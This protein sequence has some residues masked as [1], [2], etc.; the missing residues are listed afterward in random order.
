[1]ATQ[2]HLPEKWIERL[3]SILEIH[4]NHEVIRFF[5]AWAKAEGGDAEWNPLNTTNHVKSLA[6]GEWQAEDYNTTTVANY[7]H[8]WQGVLATAD[9]LEQ[10]VFGTLVYNLR[11]AKANNWTA[12]EIVQKSATDLK[13]WG[14]GSQLILDVLKTTP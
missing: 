7:N 6:H 1:M 14:T 11:H 5:T 4:I 10:T 12:E 9:T 8:P 3:C 13:N 2:T